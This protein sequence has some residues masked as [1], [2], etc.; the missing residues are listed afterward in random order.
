MQ[1]Q[2]R[3]TRRVPFIHVA[4]DDR[5]GAL[6][7]AGMAADAG[8]RPVIA[9]SLAALAVAPRNALDDAAMVVVDLQSRHLEPAGA[10]AVA[11]AV[12][13]EVASYDRWAHKID[14]TLRGNWAVELVARQGRSGDRVVVV[15]AFPAVGRI[16]RNGIVVDH[17]L[18]VA[19]AQAGRDQRTPVRSSRPIDHLLAAGAG[20][21][22]Q[23]A[24]V[25]SFRRWLSTDRSKFAVCDAATQDDL[26]DIGALWAQHP[27][28]LFAGTAASIAA[29]AG[30]AW[31]NHHFGG[32][33]DGSSSGLDPRAMREGSTLVV[34]GSLHPVARSQIEALRPNELDTPEVELS[35]HGGLAVLMTPPTAR[36]AVAP[37]A[38]ARQAASL[39]AS[40]RRL[41]AS[42]PVS[43][44][45]IVGG[46]TAAALIAD[47]PM[48]VHGTVAAGVPVGALLAATATGPDVAF[49]ARPGLR[50][51]TKSGGFGGPTTLRDIVGR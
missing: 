42:H 10:A 40:A 34:C 25:E 37:S 8:V 21:A 41:L 28:V 13:N 6:E 17:G 35:R 16:C 26:L 20:D 24:D 46:D 48:V 43:T 12:A 31:T 23:C 4:A 11:V 45:V 32:C 2:S 18:P 5:T 27:D 14:S 50:I 7:T 15:P 39:A 44:L 47:Q 1:R 30:V 22:E 38:A 51:I 36:R 49:A 29:A 3:H 9:G 19:S 33:A